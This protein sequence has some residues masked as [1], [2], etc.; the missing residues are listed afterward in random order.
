[1][2]RIGPRGI[3]AATRIVG[4]FV[5]AMGMGLI[6]HGVTEAIQTHFRQQRT[7]GR[8]QSLVPGCGH[9]LRPAAV[10]SGIAGAALPCRCAGRLVFLTSAAAITV[11]ADWIRR[12]TEQLAERAGSTIGGLLNVSFGNIAE[13]ML[14]LF[15]LPKR[16]L[17]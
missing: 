4:F 8:C 5:A 15:I 9:G 3:D 6:F 7:D 10:Y 11:L 17:G 13:L 2:G 12:A 1:M 16:I 14:A